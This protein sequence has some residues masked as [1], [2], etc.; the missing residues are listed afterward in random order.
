MAIKFGNNL[1]IGENVVDGS[2]ATARVGSMVNPTAPEQNN[3]PP[4]ATDV[5]AKKKSQYMLDVFNSTDLLSFD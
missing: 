3:I 2:T 4:V 1:I 5:D